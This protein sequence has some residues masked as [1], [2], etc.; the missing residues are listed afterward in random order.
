MDEKTNSLFTSDTVARRLLYG[1]G[2]WIPLDQFIHDL[3]RIKA[4]DFTS[5]HTCHDR[6]SLSRTFIDFMIDSLKQLPQVQQRTEILGQEFI[7]LVRGEENEETYF[8][9]VVPAARREECIEAL[10]RV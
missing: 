10:K 1:L 3:E 5:I 9:F 4:L 7:H 6:S 2:K 8:D